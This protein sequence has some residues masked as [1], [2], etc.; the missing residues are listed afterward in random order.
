MSETSFDKP[1]PFDFLGIDSLLNE[2]EVLLRD[3][4]RGFVDKEIK[5]HVADWWDDGFAASDF[6][7]PSSAVCAS[8]I[9]DVDYAT[10]TLYHGNYS[11]FLVQ[12]REDRERREKEIEQREKEIAHHQEFVDKF[13]AKNTKARQAQ[14]KLKMIEK[15]AATLEALMRALVRMKKPRSS[16]LNKDASEIAPRVS[17]VRGITGGTAR[18]EPFT[19]T[20]ST[21]WHT[22]RLQRVLL[23]SG[24]E[25]G[26]QG[27][28][29]S[30]ALDEAAQQ[31]DAEAEQGVGQPPAE[32]LVE[33][34]GGDHR[35][36]Q[37]Q[38]ALVMDMV[39][40]DRD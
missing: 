14:S 12:K 6:S 3:T 19:D 38:I 30:P 11:H 31:G 7:D 33:A 27:R 23:E 32:Q 17:K 1:D 37:Q 29:L 15:K 35:G 40:A 13:R 25:T 5:P 9:L 28:Q 18:S 16:S 36:I 21:A 8:K 4:V 20:R 24:D 26:P 10:V 2:D 39:G 22:E 34:Q